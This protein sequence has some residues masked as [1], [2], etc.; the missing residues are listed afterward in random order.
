MKYKFPA[1][2]IAAC[3]LSSFSL[4]AA[5]IVVRDFGEALGTSTF[6]TYTINNTSTAGNYLLVAV[7][8]EAGNNATAGTVSFMDD[9][10]TKLVSASS[11]ISTG[12]G[13]YENHVSIWGIATTGTGGTDSLAVG[14]NATS[15]TYVSYLFLDNVDTSAPLLGTA[16]ASGATASSATL[17]YS[18][19]PLAG[20]LV[21]VASNLATNA[22][23]NISYT[24][25]PDDQLFAYQSVPSISSLS[26]YYTFSSSATDYTTSV[27]YSSSTRYASAGVVLAAIPEPH[28]SALLAGAMGLGL[29]VLRRRRPLR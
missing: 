4:S 16:V 5:D 21:F 3:A 26:A 28:T 23:N 27:S 10:M 19:D 17:D 20:S 8:T 9:S 24:P 7:Y 2:G 14:L 18:A 22:N 1:L 13:D 12:A 15:G 11:D 25:T 6:E 29:V